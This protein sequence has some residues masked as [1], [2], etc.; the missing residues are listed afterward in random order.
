MGLNLRQL[1]RHVREKSRTRRRIGQDG[2]TQNERFGL[3]AEGEFHCLANDLDS[4]VPPLLGWFPRNRKGI[5]RARDLA[6]F[7]DHHQDVR[8]GGGV[9]P[10]GPFPC[11]LPGHGCRVRDRAGGPYRGIPSAKTAATCRGVGRTASGGAPAR[12]GTSP[13][14]TDAAAHC[15][16]TVRAST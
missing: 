4:A 11:L 8:R 1:I 9:T 2:L 13:G 5:W 3:Q 10:S 15:S 6:L 7:R 16:P 12:L 14:W